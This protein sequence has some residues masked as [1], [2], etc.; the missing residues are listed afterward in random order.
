[1]YTKCNKIRWEKYIYFYNR[2]M[3][4]ICWETL[5]FI[6]KLKAPDDDDDNMK[7]IS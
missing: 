6:H 4:T 3:W 7:N 1:M 2:D 5:L